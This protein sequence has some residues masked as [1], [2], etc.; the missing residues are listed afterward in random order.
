[1]SN[2]V[3]SSECSNNYCNSIES[4]EHSRRSDISEDDLLLNLNKQFDTSRSD[5]GISTI[6]SA[7]SKTSSTLSSLLL[8]EHHNNNINNNNNYFYDEHSQN[9]NN[10]GID[11]VKLLKLKSTEDETQ[12]ISNSSSL[13]SLTSLDNQQDSL[14]HNANADDEDGDE[15]GSGSTSCSE[16]SF[17]MS[18]TCSN[19]ETPETS[20]LRG[21]RN[22][23]KTKWNQTRLHKGLAD[24][25]EDEDE[26]LG[27][28]LRR[29]HP[30]LMMSTTSSGIHDVSMT[31]TCQ[32]VSRASV[33][34][35][36]SR[37]LSNL[38]TGL[39]EL[40]FDKLEEQLKQ[41][42][43]EREDHERK[44]LGEEVRRRLALQVDS[45]TGPCP[46]VNTRPNRSNL[47]MRLQ[48]A[49]NLQVCYMNELA[50]S[51]AEEDDDDDDETTDSENEEED[52]N[53][54]A[55]SSFMSKSR[56]SPNLRKSSRPGSS[57]EAPE[58]ER[59]RQKALDD[60][61]LD[62]YERQKLLVSETRRVLDSAKLE[63]IRS[64][65]HFRRTK[66]KACV[67][68]RQSR[69]HLSKMS[70][71]Q[72]QRIHDIMSSAIAQKNVE[73]VNLLIDRDG[74]HMEHDSLLVDIEDFTEHEAQASAL[75]FRQL[76]RMQT[77]DLPPAPRS[78]S[79]V[80]P[81][82][83]GSS[84]S[85]IKN[86]APSAKVSAPTPLTTPTSPSRSFVASLSLLSTSLPALPKSL[87]K[88]SLFGTNS[89][90]S[91]STSSSTS[92]TNSYR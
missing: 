37:E 24:D 31:N 33:R 55:F 92:T 80:G 7:Y 79:S 8:A 21:G 71:Q 91:S 68:P 74:L 22:D 78:V 64:A 1:M 23:V 50:E 63:A 5:S 39:P 28:C 12:Q 72:I 85:E 38:D 82:F 15:L 46:V 61:E 57:K 76:L 19:R 16:D 9:N 36:I 17:E 51:T 4:I 66:S 27:D 45:T 60:R 88:F 41:A 11:V 18:S 30:E 84:T 47:A 52:D 87:S 83:P 67:V 43:R 56:S 25:D 3:V 20:P 81:T 6:D 77:G 53:V 70:W 58:L 73:L 26:L 14:E 62:G 49:M 42:A 86:R 69:Q 59:L 90:S 48:T 44:L 54:S 34:E 32:S 75:D 29:I 35:S 13:E 10:N 40:D 2:A 89:S 65:E